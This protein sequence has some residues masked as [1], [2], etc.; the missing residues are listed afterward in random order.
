MR[1][2]FCVRYKSYIMNL[3]SS[4]V[5]QQCGTEFPK[6][7]GKCTSC[8]AWNSLVESL[9]MTRKSKNTS[10]NLSSV[11]RNSQTVKLIDIKTS[12]IGRTLT[13]ISELDRCLGGGLVSGQVVL[14][15][16]EP[17]IGKSTLLLQVANSL[18]N[19]LYV[20]GEESANQVAIRSKR[21]NINNKSI[22]FLESTDVDETIEQVSKIKNQLSSIIIDSIQTMSTSDLNGLAGSV[23][24]V[25][26]TT[27]RLLR[28][29]KERGIPLII[30]GH[31]TKEGTVAG[32][33]VLSHIVDTVLWFEGER[34]S[35]LRILRSRKNRFG[36]TDEVGIFS[37]EEGGLI[38]VDNAEKIFLENVGGKVSGSSTSMLL[39]GTR[40]MLVEIQSLV[41][42]TKLAIPRRVAQGI[43]S[44]RL[45]MLLAVLSRRV[46]IP[47]YEMDVFVNL[48]GGIK[49]SDPALDLAVCL[50]VASSY[51]EKALPDKLLILGEV[52]LLGEIRKVNMQDK[53]INDAR[54]LGFKL[55]AS[56][57]DFKFL[58]EVIKEY[59]K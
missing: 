29:A 36:S 22:Q 11:A 55:T 33:S 41:V 19:T 45:E 40:S 5:C 23:G 35:N 3:K 59:I 34:N 30:V 18:N 38:S 6:W 48:A 13:G 31:V 4:F 17:G 32:P 8:N 57:K 58:K 47:L 39:E 27:F 53:R 46:G 42:P 51:Y 37:M 21:L 44:R 52:G 9:K 1:Y 16:G 20:S 10:K 49:A 43:D 12:K 14:I 28:V 54:R 50:S 24:Q 15:A 25:R 26:E 56:P 2:L 7:L